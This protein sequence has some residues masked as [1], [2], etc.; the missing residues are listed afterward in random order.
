MLSIALVALAASA[1]RIFLITRD[2]VPFA[3]DMGRDLLWAKDIVF[4]QTPTLIGPAAS[5]WG[6]YFGPLW[7]YFLTLPLFITDGHPLSAVYATAATVVAT[8]ILAFFLFKKYLG[9]FYALV[10][11]ILILFNGT[12]INIS[13]FA[14]HANVL[15][16]LTLLMVYFCYLAVVKKPVYIFGAFLS[17]SLMFHADP[18]PAVVNTFIPIAIAA[19]YKIYKSKNFKMVILYSLVAYLAPFIPQILFELRNNFIQTKSLLAYFLGENPSLSGQLPFFERVTNRI[20]LFFDFFKESFTPQSNFLTVGVLFFIAF[21]IYLFFQR[22]KDRNSQI[23]AKINLFSLILTFIIFTFLVTVEVKQWYL[24]GIPVIYAFLTTI[25]LLAAKKNKFL[26]A[27]FLIPFIF[28][29]VSPF[30]TSDRAAS[31][32]VDPALLAN[33]LAA[34][35]MIY[36][37]ALLTPFSVYIFTPSIYDYNYQYLFWWQGQ[38][39]GEGLPQDFAYLPSQPDYVRNKNFYVKIPQQSNLTYLIIENA[40]ENEFYTKDNWLKN[41]DDYQLA[42]EKDINSAITVQKRQK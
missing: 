6:V 17:V 38:K 39:L 26:L 34:I 8:G 2:S 32:K 12:L 9:V 4:Y 3:Y 36:D 1:L 10:L 27:V 5:I 21:G 22:V 31:S 37:D 24:Y 23:L 20:D 42:W 11:S 25:A 28:L 35:N 15:P 30:L 7:F 19:I 18:A 14:F 33:Q 40:P 29:N 41:F 13:T 16:L